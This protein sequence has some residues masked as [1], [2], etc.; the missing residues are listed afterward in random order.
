[1]R[2]HHRARVCFACRAGNAPWDVLA[3]TSVCPDCQ[4][5]LVLGDGDVYL[6]LQVDRCRTCECCGESGTVRYHSVPARRDKHVS[7]DLCGACL[8]ALL[9]RC[10]GRRAYRALAVAL[11][12]RNLLISDFWLLSGNFYDGRGRARNPVV[13][14]EADQ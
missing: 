5:R 2:T 4:E 9:G 14:P 13:P 11:G 1:M 3:G 7:I 8:R 12:R 10:L 6:Q